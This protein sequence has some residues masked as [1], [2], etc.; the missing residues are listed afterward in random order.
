MRACPLPKW[1]RRI[2]AMPWCLTGVA[3]DT[4]L[5]GGTSNSFRWSVFVDV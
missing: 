5:S 4:S 2:S 3:G 1:W